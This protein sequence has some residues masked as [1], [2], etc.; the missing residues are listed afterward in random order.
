MLLTFPLS[1][2][3][4]RI[5]HPLSPHQPSQSHLCPLPSLFPIL[6]SA[7]L[8]ASP[9]PSKPLTPQ[10]LPSALHSSRFSTCP[11]S[12]TSMSSLLS[13]PCPFSPAP[14]TSPRVMPSAFHPPPPSPSPVIS[15]PAFLLP[16]P[17][18][19]S[20]PPINPTSSSSPVSPFSTPSSPLNPNKSSSAP[21]RQF[22]YSSGKFVNAQGPRSFTAARSCARAASSGQVS[23]PSHTREFFLGNRISATHFLQCR[24]RTPRYLFLSFLACLPAAIVDRKGGTVMA[25]VVGL[26]DAS[27]GAPLL[28]ASPPS[29]GI[30]TAAA[31][32]LAAIVGVSLQQH[33]CFTCLCCF[34]PASGTPD[35]SAAPAAMPTPTANNPTTAFPSTITPNIPTTTLTIIPSPTMPSTTTPTATVPPHTTFA[36]QPKTLRSPLSAYCITHLFQFDLP[37]LLASPYFFC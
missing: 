18:S 5:I 30:R 36:I 35:C 21:F 15:I 6:P 9:T 22:S 32:S 7:P 2:C 16:S 23:V 28:L 8:L 1:F 3:L 14:R 27:R 20:L 33:L 4:L 31:A 13:L 12:I 29:R 11:L 17:P 26:E 37:C 24:C 25:L 10:L 34:P 19:A